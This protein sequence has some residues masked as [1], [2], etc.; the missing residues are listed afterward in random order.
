MWSP[1]VA[2]GS[3]TA[4]SCP[5]GTTAQQCPPRGCLPSGAAAP[6]LCTQWCEQLK[7][8]VSGF[9]CVVDPRSRGCTHTM[10]QTSTT[11]VRSRAQG[12]VQNAARGVS[13]R[14]HQPGNQDKGKRR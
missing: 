8:T 7:L 10:V 9:G 3:G 11:L 5:R 2:A 6:G 13:C 4:A 1:W 12:L 14:G